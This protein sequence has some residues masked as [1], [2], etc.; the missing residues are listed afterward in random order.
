MDI[1]MTILDEHNEFRTRFAA[2][3]QMRGADPETLK[4][5]WKQLHI[6]LD[7]HAEA[8]ERMFYPPLLKIG[9]GANDASSAE[10][11]AVDAI[12]DHN[13]IRDAS[14]EVEKYQPGSDDWFSA[15][16]KANVANNKHMAEEE[17]QALTDFRRHAS[18]QERHDLAVKYLGYR[19]R[20]AG[21][22]DA[23]NDDPEK[24]IA[25]HTS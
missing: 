8:E 11:E 19:Y 12:E 13:K 3:E 15:V 4:A 1:T 7:V 14:A 22:I 23:K 18:L 2:I 21:G 16:Q 24:Y 5:V 10:D 6:L 9:T 25:E 17:R 20:N